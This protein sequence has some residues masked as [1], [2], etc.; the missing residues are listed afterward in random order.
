M[1]EKQ[2]R[3]LT[4]LASAFIP[5]VIIV[6][7]YSISQGLP[8]TGKNTLLMIDMNQQYVDFYSFLRQTVLHGQWSNLFFSFNNGLGSDTW[9]I[10]A[11]YLMSPF[12]LILLLFSEKMITS[13]IFIMMLL[14]YMAAA[15]S[16]TALLR[17]LRY[18][19]YF[20]IPL[21]VIYALSG[22]GVAYQ[23]DLMWLD[24]LVILPL[25]IL[26][27]ILVF[28]KSA[29]SLYTAMVAIA[30]IDN[31]YMGYMMLLFSGLYFIFRWLTTTFISRK[32]RWIM[33]KDYILSTLVGLVMSL[34]FWVPTFLQLQASKAS[35]HTDFAFDWLKSPTV[36]VIKTFAGSYN[37]N[38][39]RT[40]GAN[41]YVGLFVLV[42]AI[43]YF[44]NS[45]IRLRERI[46][47]FLILALLYIS[48]LNHGL[49][50][51]W[52]AFQNPIWYPFRFSYLISFWLVLL[53]GRQLHFRPSFSLLQSIIAFVMVLIWSLLGFYLASFPD[54]SFANPS[55]MLGDMLIGL[56]LSVLMYHPF[57]RFYAEL[58]LFK[59]FVV[60]GLLMTAMFINYSHSSQ[61]ISGISED[62]YQ[63]G[64]KSL[65]NMKDVN[66]DTSNRYRSAALL[67][68]SRNDAL[69]LGYHGFSEFSSTTDAETSQFLRNLG[70]YQSSVSYIYANGTLLS[71]ALFGI[72]T[73]T[74]DT[75][76]AADSLIK[77]PYRYD[78]NVY[79][80]KHY[81]NGVVRFTNNNALPL[82][83]A[84]KGNLFSDD[85]SMPGGFNHQIQW[86]NSVAPGKNI[87]MRYKSLKPKHYFKKVNGTLYQYYVYTYTGVKGGINYVEEPYGFNGTGDHAF[88]GRYT[89][90]NNGKRISLPIQSSTSLVI[91]TDN[92]LKQLNKIVV[93]TKFYRQLNWA[94]LKLYTIDPVV[95]HQRIQKVVQRNANVK[96]DFDNAGKV[97]MDIDTKA[98]ETIATSIAYNP[99]YVITDNGKPVDGKLYQNAL[100]SIPVKAGQHH[101]EITYQVKGLSLAFLVSSVGCVLW[102]IW[103]IYDSRRYF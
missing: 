66:P 96:M 14:K 80:K 44:F 18:E 65:N 32:L 75:S 64:M 8:F 86:L 72:H 47:S 57:S 38:E 25:L 46:G 22:W 1:S 98:G 51:I 61:I 88:S 101:I 28:E 84:V 56:V 94:N 58:G 71:D 60:V 10:W 24:A 11:Y 81:E 83:F 7:T 49:A 15:V 99:N 31:Y 4:Y 70:I 63:S 100:L 95:L 93:R 48:T 45:D 102:L 92:N 5:M 76:K 68:R 55:A 89:W 40:G 13:A 27:L 59:R 41:M 82:A 9:G 19:D 43:F 53:A 79:K 33:L 90:H 34:W 73:I 37:F 85:I 20:V 78:V 62:A 29:L 21:S 74:S 12:N 69:H 91:N 50:L 54:L 3:W 2:K 39:L 17:H 26:G 30:L 35:Y 97:S 67:Y 23:L 6:I 87:V 42:L 52:Q 16:M 77:M 36:S 103:F